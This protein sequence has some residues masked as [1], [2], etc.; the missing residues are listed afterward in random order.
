MS[1]NIYL[2]IDPKYFEVNL[3]QDYYI[4]K[5]DLI[6]IPVL[7]NYIDISLLNEETGKI[8]ITDFSYEKLTEILKIYFRHYQYISII[9]GYEFLNINKVIS[10]APADEK[11]IENIKLLPKR[12]FY[13]A[14]KSAGMVSWKLL[15]NEFQ[16]LMKIIMDVF[17][18]QKDKVLE[19]RTFFI[20]FTDILTDIDINTVYY[21]LI[22][23]MKEF[24]LTI[25]HRWLNTK[26]GEIPFACGYFC[27]LKDFIQVK[28]LNA[29]HSM[30][31]ESL[32][33]FFKDFMEVYGS[34]ISL[35]SIKFDYI[36]ALDGSTY[37]VINIHLKINEDENTIQIFLNDGE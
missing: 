28:N 26:E 36:T 5:E 17:F 2:S 16:D 37:I 35:K 3:N 32:H 19:T 6:N 29:I 24:F 12:V 34:Y 13:K 4:D 30:I 22:T 33:L 15:K 8:T 23:D 10:L 31:E 1:S 18:L 14:D 27:P 7:Y 25:F 9:S 21:E 20:N 11:L